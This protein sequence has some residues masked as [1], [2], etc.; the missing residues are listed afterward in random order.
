MPSNLVINT[1]SVVGYNNKLQIA[2]TGMKPGKNNINL[3][4]TRGV[5]HFVSPPKQE[6]QPLKKRQPPKER[7]EDDHHLLKAGLSVVSIGLGYYL[8]R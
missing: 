4:T 7:P 2:T 6:H 1:G 8:M 3:K 5:P